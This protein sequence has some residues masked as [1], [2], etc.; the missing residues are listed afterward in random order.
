MYKAQADRHR[1]P[2]IY[3]RDASELAKLGKV[4][5]I[6]VG[7]LEMVVDAAELIGDA[8]HEQTASADLLNLGKTGLVTVIG[9]TAF[10]LLHKRLGARADELQNG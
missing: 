3:T 5:M 9:A 4:G 7:G 8:V 1:P 2:G 10:H 6:A